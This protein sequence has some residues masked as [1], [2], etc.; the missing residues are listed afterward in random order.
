MLNIQISPH[1]VIT[2]CPVMKTGIIA[3]VGLGHLSF[4]H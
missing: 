4:V 1:F 3:V 2:G